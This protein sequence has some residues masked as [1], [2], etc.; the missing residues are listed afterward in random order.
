MTTIKK[1]KKILIAN[2]GEIAV[3]VL[4]SC[5]DMGITSVAVYSDPD[6]NALHVRRAD[7]AY[8]IGP[9]A[10]AQSYLNWKKIIEV[11]K[12]S[13][14]DA[15]HPG[16]GFLSEN[17]EFAKEIEKAGITFIGPN[18]DVIY[19]MGSKIESRKI[20]EAAGIPLIPGIQHPLQDVE[21]AAEVAKKIG[22]P[23][24]IKAA[25]GGGGKGMREVH[26]EK[27][28]K[29]AFS[30]AQNEAIA[31]FNDKD[32]YIEKLIEGPHHIEVQVFGDHHGNVVPLSFYHRRNSAK[33]L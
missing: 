24:L 18:P 2:R 15:I 33:R 4:R 25:A 10:P 12:K 17:T 9:A 7:E 16:Y 3:R 11:A 32:V 19:N 30:M 23:I 20:A 22:Y 21:E 26:S 14:A 31:S 28:L 5:R 6:R 27:D 29:S 1:I 13:K 8:H